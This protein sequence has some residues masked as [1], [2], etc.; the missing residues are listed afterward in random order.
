MLDRVYAIE[1]LE[2]ITTEEKEYAKG[3]MKK[4]NFDMKYPTQQE[5]PYTYDV[6][7][8]NFKNTNI[9]PEDH[10]GIIFGH[11]E[12]ATFKLNEIKICEHGMTSEN[13]LSRAP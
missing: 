4:M 11:F 6:I 12:I 3:I 5:Q 2:D 7:M 13:L 9:N 10:L 1:W 8:N